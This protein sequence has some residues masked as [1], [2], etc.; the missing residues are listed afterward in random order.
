MS[1]SVCLCL[2]VCVCVSLS[3]CVSVSVPVHVSICERLCVFVRAFEKEIQTDRESKLE[4]ERQ[5]VTENEIE[6]Q[7]LLLLLVGCL[8]SQQ[9]ASVSH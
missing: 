5:V 1:V 3:L 8:T 9:Y 6:G 7:L 4:R 2:C